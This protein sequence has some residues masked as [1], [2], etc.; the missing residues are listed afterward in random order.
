MKD[1]NVSTYKREVLDVVCC[2]NKAN[3][4]PKKTDVDILAGLTLCSIKEFKTLLSNPTFNISSRNPSCPH[5]VAPRTRIL[6]D[7]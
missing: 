4:S 1:E 7:K 2:L 5:L 3:E 6:L